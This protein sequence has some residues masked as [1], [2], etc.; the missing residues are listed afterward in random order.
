MIYLE[1]LSL[2]WK[3]MFDSWLETLAPALS[4]DNGKLIE[5]LFETFVPPCVRFVHKSCKEVWF[6]LNK[7]YYFITANAE[8]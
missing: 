1:P 6:Y 7:F 8:F 2:G 3:P 4:E 5:S